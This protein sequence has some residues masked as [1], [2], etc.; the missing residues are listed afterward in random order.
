MKR[1]RNSNL[2]QFVDFEA[3]VEEGE[4]AESD[5]DE[6]EWGAYTFVACEYPAYH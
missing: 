2:N 6:D 5:S 4:E 3:R 1:A